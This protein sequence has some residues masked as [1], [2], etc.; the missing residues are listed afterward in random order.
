MTADPG[1][2]A[3]DWQNR[4]T[5][6]ASGFAESTIDSVVGTQTFFAAGEGQPMLLLHG[7]GDSAAAWVKAAPPL[8]AMGQYRILIP[9]LPGHGTSQPNAGPLDM[10]IFLEGLNAVAR[11]AAE[12]P[13]ILIGNS[14][15]AWLAMVWADRNPARV[16]RIVAVDGSGLTGIR[17]DLALRPADR[18]QARRLW[19]TLVDSAYWN[20]PEMVYD[21]MIRRGRVG[22]V[23][24]MVFDRMKQF[25]MDG[26]LADFVTPVDLIWGESDGLLNLEYAQTVAA[27][28]PMARLSTI[29]GCGHVPQLECAER[30]NIMLRGLLSQP[31]P[32]RSQV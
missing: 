25:V 32:S 29:P 4:R 7:A 14:L 10:E 26:R 9:D 21:E 30:F 2:N 1:M 18:A 3:M 12:S 11:L 31:P 13:A 15:G 5:L 17:D 8:L 16:A 20:V 19:Q 28:L 22:A 27:M 24:R 23:S 6:A